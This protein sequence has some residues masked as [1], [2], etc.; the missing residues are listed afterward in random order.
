MTAAASPE[1]IPDRLYGRRRG[2]PLRARQQ[3][4][5]EVTLPRLR[6]SPRAAAADPRAAF[7]GPVEEVWLEVGFGGG[8]HLLWQAERNPAV[9]FIG[10]EPFID[11]IVKVLTAIEDRRLKNIRLYAGDARTV[12]RW[13]PDGSIGRAFVLFPDPWPKKRH[14]KRRIVSQATLALLARVMRAGA[15]PSFSPST[16]NQIFG[17]WPRARRTGAC[18]RPI[19]RQPAMSK[20]PFGRAGVVPTS[21]WSGPNGA[22]P[23]VPRPLDD[24]VAQV[25]VGPFAEAPALHRA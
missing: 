5:L 1:G 19:G 3:R 21:G 7:P 25:A 4:L 11:G 6:L 17:G 2:H 22:R 8:E 9:G 14:R 16:P 24:V 12:L 13:L 23:L 18:A 15:A 20:R 10:C